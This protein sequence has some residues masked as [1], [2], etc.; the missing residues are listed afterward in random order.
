MLYVKDAL[1]RLRNGNFTALELSNLFGQLTAANVEL[2]RLK[3]ELSDWKGAGVKI[4]YELH[5]AKIGSAGILDGVC[6]L[7]KQRD[8]LLEN[9]K[10]LAEQLSDLDGALDPTYKVEHQCA[11]E[12]L[13]AHNKLMEQF[14]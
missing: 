7:I 14:K 4:A 3:A 2:E 9:S 13:A 12:A 11:K 1:D 8:A 10:R 5:M 6:W